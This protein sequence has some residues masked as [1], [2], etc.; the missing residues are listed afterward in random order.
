MSGGVDSSVA[1]ALLRERGH[2]ITGICMKLWD[3]SPLP[4]GPYHACYGPDEAEDIEDARQVAAFLTIPFYVIDVTREYKSAVLD[5]FRQEY[6]AGRTPNPCI[7]CNQQIK[8]KTLLAKARLAGVSFDYFATGHYARVDFCR[9]K[10]RYVLRRG[11]D[12]HKDQSYWLAFLSQEQLSTL[13]LPLGDYTKHEVRGKASE[14][15]LQTHDKPDSQ[16]FFSGDYQ[17]LINVPSCPGPIVDRTGAV[18]GTHRGIWLYTVGQRKGLGIAAR[19]PLYVLEIDR[20]KN[21]VVVGSR[22]ELAQGCL[23]A[24]D[25]NFISVDPISRPRKV[26]VKIRYAQKPFEATLHPPEHG[27][28]QVTFQEPQLAVTPG[29]AVVFYDGDCVVGGGIIEKAAQ[30]NSVIA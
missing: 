9:V 15:G 16:D 30:G 17:E 27:A 6:L 5:Y 22:E 26:Q 12:M 19:K 28:V 14:L 1:A 7:R 4:A 3:G 29:Q 21:T 8:F 10:G 11:K 18:L 20:E 23:T 24:R 13:I 2:D 25:V